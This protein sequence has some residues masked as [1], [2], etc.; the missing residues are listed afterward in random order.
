MRPLL[1][2]GVTG[3]IGSG[4]STVCRLFALY[5]VPVY[6]CDLGARVLMEQDGTLIAKIKELLGAE[7]YKD[8]KP[9]RAR[10]ASQVF[11]SP[12][13][14]EKLDALVHPAVGADFERW[15]SGRTGYVVME[16]AILFESGFDARVDK[17]VVV[18]APA[19]LR[20]GRAVARGAVRADVERRMANQMDPQQAA[21]RAD[22]VIQND[23]EHSLVEQVARL[24]K[25]FSDGC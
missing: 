11:N 18:D 2:I 3:G 8:G 1:K 7:S 22:Y 23:P 25:L 10:I 9:D 14:L 16:S 5:G 20:I 24:H 12:E 15:A 21:A 19:E 4:K 6:D 17:T 13:L